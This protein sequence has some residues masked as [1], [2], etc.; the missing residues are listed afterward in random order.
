MFG[1]DFPSTLITTVRGLFI[2]VAYALSFSVAPA[3][4]L[5]CMV[6]VAPFVFRVRRTV[7]AVVKDQTR[8]FCRESQ[9]SRVY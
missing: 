8:S 1:D 4:Y 9:T 2:L 5:L 7:Q 6:S 3:S